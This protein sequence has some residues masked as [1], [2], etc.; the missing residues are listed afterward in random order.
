[1]RFLHSKSGGEVALDQIVTMRSVGRGVEAATV[2]KLR[3]GSTVEFWQDTDRISSMLDPV[4]PAQPGFELLRVWLG[5]NGLVEVI[6]DSVIAWRVNAYGVTPITV[7]GFDED[8]A[9]KQ[10]TGRVERLEENTWDNVEEWLK[11]EVPRQRE[12]DAKEKEEHEKWLASKQAKEGK[13]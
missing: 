3:D 6:A 11:D 2:A 5:E 13:Q 7:H 12:K 9:I 4:I 10:P 1:M 8:S